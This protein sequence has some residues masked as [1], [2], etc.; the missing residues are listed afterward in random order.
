[1]KLLVSLISLLILGQSAYATPTYKEPPETRMCDYVYLELEDAASRNL[2]TMNQA[3]RIYDNCMSA[4]GYT[5]DPTEEHCVC[6]RE[7]IYY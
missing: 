3:D 6:I 1:M 4:Y 7:N 5:I 2:I